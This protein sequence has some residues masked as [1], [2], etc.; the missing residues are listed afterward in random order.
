[1]QICA[2]AN[3]GEREADPHMPPIKDSDS[4]LFWLLLEQ[5]EQG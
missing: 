4:F 3:Y 2:D 5:L 1:M